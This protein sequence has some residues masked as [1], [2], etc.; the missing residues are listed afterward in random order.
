M[1]IWG[2]VLLNL[3]FFVILEHRN[4]LESFPVVIFSWVL[5]LVEHV[6]KMLALDEDLQSPKQDACQMFSE[7][8]R[9]RF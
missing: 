5:E 1:D 8:A 9:L 7:Q 6:I 3:N 4:F 2:R